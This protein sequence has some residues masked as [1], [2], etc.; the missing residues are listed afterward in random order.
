MT[1]M[2]ATVCWAW[3]PPCAATIRRKLS[4]IESN[5]P[6]ISKLLALDLHVHSIKRMACVSGSKDSFSP[7]RSYDSLT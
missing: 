2:V 1:V 6:D 3:P 4:G 7:L 5:Q